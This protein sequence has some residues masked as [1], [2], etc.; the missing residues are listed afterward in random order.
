MF[1]CLLK[2]DVFYLFYLKTKKIYINFTHL[3]KVIVFP[4]FCLFWGFY[5]CLSF[6]YCP[7]LF[8]FFFLPQEVN[9]SHNQMSEMKDLSAYSSL[10]KLILDCILLKIAKHDTSFSTHF[11]SLMYFQ[12]KQAI[13]TEK[14]IYLRSR[15]SELAMTS[16]LSWLHSCTKVG[17]PR[18]M[19]LLLA[20]PVDLNL[21]PK[22]SNYL[23]NY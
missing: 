16:H 1:F 23:T 10:T 3:I 8:L 12:V 20:V 9:F 2:L 5:W 15:M 11:T 6:T 17:K 22:Y 13:Q 21:N 4:S 19:P 14:N 7:F 18:W